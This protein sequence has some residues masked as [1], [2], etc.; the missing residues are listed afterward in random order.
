M[1]NEKLEARNAAKRLFAGAVQ[2]AFA[3]LDNSG[4][5]AD[6]VALEVEKL[7]LPGLL[8]KA[9]E[10]VEKKHLAST[11]M[12][13]IVA[14][15]QAKK[16]A[17]AKA[18]HEAQQRAKRKGFIR[19]FLSDNT[20]VG[21]QEI[22]PVPIV[23]SDDKKAV[24]AKIRQWLAENVETEQ[25]YPEEGFL[26]LLYQGHAIEDGV[27]LLDSG[28]PEAPV[29]VPIKVDA[30]IPSAA[31]AVEEEE[32]TGEEVAAGE[33]G[34]ASAEAGSAGAEDGVGGDAGEAAAE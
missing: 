28:I 34:D 12:S 24:E 11:I 31:P 27:P 6:P 10:L 17:R 25:E 5:F 1:F 30:T 21:V 2:D 20:L 4:Y 3:D 33:E 7:F 22:G 15:A 14:K 18:L 13:E 16:E 19:I 29:E 8:G 32:E 23:A 9:V 26:E